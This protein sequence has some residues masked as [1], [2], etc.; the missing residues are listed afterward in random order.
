M[1]LISLIL[2][3]TFPGFL[4]LVSQLSLK[5]QIA[6]YQGSSCHVK[7]RLITLKYFQTSLHPAFFAFERI[8]WQNFL[9]EEF[10]KIE[11]LQWLV[12]RWANLRNAADIKK[13][14][15]DKALRLQQFHADITE[16]KVYDISFKRYTI[17]QPNKQA[18]GTELY[19][20]LIILSH[21]V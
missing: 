4:V 13:A 12:F 11:Y 15:L 6:S 17:K 8:P 7:T 3:L 19:P 10:Q 9:Q 18:Q 14:K 21:F 2:F 1:L 20:L 5:K 16:T